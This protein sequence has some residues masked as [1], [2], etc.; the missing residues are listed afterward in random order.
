MI[1]ALFVSLLTPAALA[2]APGDFSFTG[3]ILTAAMVPWG[4]TVGSPSVVYNSVDDTYYMFFESRLSATDPDC[5]V[6]QWAIG[7]ATSP[8]GFDS[9]TVRPNPVIEP[10]PAGSTFH[11]CVAAHPG[12]HYQE[13]NAGLGRGVINV[14]FKAEQSDDNCTPTAQSWG[15]EQ[16]TGI[17]RYRIR[18]AGG[19]FLSDT[20]FASPVIEKDANFGYP[21]P[22]I[23]DGTW[24]LSYGVYP[25]VELATA[26]NASGP[27]TERGVILDQNTYNS[28]PD[29]SW[30]EN[31]FFSPALS[32]EQGET[33]P[34]ELWV[35][36]RDT[37]YSFVVDGGLGLAVTA[38]GQPGTWNLSEDPY[39]DILDDDEFRHWDVLRVD[40]GGSSEVLMWFDEKDA[41]G[42]NEIHLA[43]TTASTSSWDNADVY[44]KECD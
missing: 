24:L 11:N 34:L 18:F 12:A 8:N 41:S 39:F 13:V 30:M 42:N 32:C 44:L 28:D 5:P 16:Y 6:G 36:G 20:L 40:E 22:L 4:E 15:C 37:L 33:F 7:L 2:Q 23:F 25:N 31:E 1:A 27:W 43:Y 3:P 38:D 9:W 14:Y 26:P 10:N 35:G 17:G 19:A 21:K 29:Y